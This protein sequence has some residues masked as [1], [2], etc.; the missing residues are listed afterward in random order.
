MT[1]H[2]ERRDAAR[3]ATISALMVVAAFVAGK[4]A[5]DAILLSHFSIRSLPLFIG[6]AA[7][8]SLPVILIAGRLMTRFGPERLVPVLNVVSAA[9]AVGEWLLLGRYPRVI[10]VVVFIHLSTASAVLV[11]GFWSIINERFD[12]QTAKRHIGRIGMGATLGGILGGVITERTAVHLQPDMILLV[13]AGLQL[14]CAVTLFAFGR[15]SLPEAVEVRS[16]GTWSAL[17][18]AAKAPLFRNVGVIVVL[19][20]V[21][22]G[23]LDYVFKADIVAAS[24][25]DDLLRSLAV[26]YTITNILTA[27]IQLSVCGPILARIGVPRSVAT[28]PITITA[29]SMVAL[30]VPIPMSAAFARAAELVTRNSVFRSGYELLYAPL[31]EE[32][33]RPTKVV[34]D[35]GADKI[36]DILGAQLVALIVVAAID[37]RAVLLLAAVITGVVALLFAIRL[38]A[39]YTKALEDSLLV[40]AA[41]VGAGEPAFPAHPEPWLSLTDLPTFGDPDAVPLRMRS[42][43]RR[44]NTLPP[45]ARV[46]RGVHHGANDPIVQWI[47]DLRSGDVARVRHAL[48]RPIPPEVAAHVIDLVGREDVGRDAASA[49]EPIARICTGMLADAL[50]DQR[51]SAAIRRRIPAILVLAEP[52]LAAW[53]LWKALSDPDFDVRY[54]AGAVLAKLA[55]EGHLTNVTE[56]EVFEAVRRELL[57]DPTEWR[58]RQLVEDLVASS[59]VGDDDVRVPSGLEHVFRVLG[60]VLPAEPLRIALHAMQVD[61][62]ALRGTA[63]EYL[64]SILPPDVRAQ[65]WPLLETEEPA[66]TVA[67]ASAVAAAI[68]QPPIAPRA[69]APQPPHPRPSRS[70]D[71]LVAELSGAYP[72]VVS[73][74]KQRRNRA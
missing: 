10:A 39:S 38:P 20:A 48:G 43:A 55:A 28:L 23:L 22:A 45:T 69:P 6:I 64:E 57:A 26:F 49:L 17:R 13:L 44:R 50:L 63:L 67:V 53:A 40:H 32:R 11:S 74:L 4:A 68:P 34:L 25:Q 21:A 65:L 9:F 62:P 24:S 66:V 27:V 18:H 60:L 33:K 42:R 36:G 5:R 59:H 2:D 7:V 46:I 72:T 31:P 16:E 73:R 52:R 19:G 47:A 29:F 1:A 51:R 58:T 70:M 12:V 71:Q 15:T 35:V 3:V 56:E 37:V 14:A 61:D 30:M 54:R 41:E 8:L